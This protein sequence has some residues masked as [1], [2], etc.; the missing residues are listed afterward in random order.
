MRTGR[1]RWDPERLTY[2]RCRQAKPVSTPLGVYRVVET[3]LWRARE[4]AGSHPATTWDTNDV[5]CRFWPVLDV[6]MRRPIAIWGD[7]ML[8]ERAVRQ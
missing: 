6:G 2:A 8:V 7:V 3:D 5:P 1:G 4:L